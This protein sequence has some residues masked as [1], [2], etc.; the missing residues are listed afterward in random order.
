MKNK[1]HPSFV[2][3]LKIEELW[4][5]AHLSKKRDPISKNNQSKKG[6]EVLFVVRALA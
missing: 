3:K 4:S 2:G 1:A 6:L 5:L